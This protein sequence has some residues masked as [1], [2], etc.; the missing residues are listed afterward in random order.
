M[1]RENQAIGQGKVFIQFFKLLMY[2][3]QWLIGL[4]F[5]DVDG[6]VYIQHI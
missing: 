6:Y 2:R 1:T 5:I 3:V 4:A